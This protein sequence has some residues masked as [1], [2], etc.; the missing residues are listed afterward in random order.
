MVYLLPKLVLI[1]LVVTQV[2]KG[3]LCDDSVKTKLR[4]KMGDS[5]LDNC[6]IRYIEP[7]IFFE[8]DEDYIIETF[9][10]QEAYGRQVKQVVLYSL[11]HI[12]NYLYGSMSFAV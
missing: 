9:M 3:C 6:L 4:N 8:V 10:S 12:L 7:D 2:M 5:P 1:L 11:M